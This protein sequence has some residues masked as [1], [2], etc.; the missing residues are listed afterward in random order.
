MKNSTTH[1]SAASSGAVMSM[2]SI[3]VQHYMESLQSLQSTWLN[4]ED[5]ADASH[6]ELQLDYLIRL[7]PDFKTQDEI[8]DRRQ[9]EFKRMKA[10]K[11]RYGEFEIQMRSGLVVV[12]YLIQFIC[13]SFD[14]LHVDIVG[15]ATSKQYRD[16]ILEIPDMPAPPVMAIENQ[17]VGQEQ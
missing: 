9:I 2:D 17:A 8:L 6:F 7:I 16:A 15:P 10:D 4:S 5:P 12:T 1:A 3:F 14:L 11:G 13:N